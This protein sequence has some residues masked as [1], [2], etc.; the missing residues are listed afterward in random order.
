MSISNNFQFLVKQVETDALNL[1]EDEINL[2]NSVRKWVDEIVRPNA[3][4]AWEKGELPR[5]WM[6]TIAAKGWLSL[7]LAQEYGGNLQPFRMYALL[8][9]ELERGDS[10]LRSFVSVHCSL[11]MQAIYRFGS[12]EQ[13]KKYLPRMATGELIGSFSLTEPD[14]GSD[15]STIKTT[16]TKQS[17]DYLLQGH[18]RWAT[19]ST[20]ADLA[21]IFAKTDEGIRGFVLEKGDRGFE[22]RGVHQKGSLRISES[23]EILLNS[24]LI[25]GDRLLPGTAIGIAAPLSCLSM[26]RSGIAWGMIG[27]ARHCF[28]LALEY[29]KQRRQFGSSLAGKQLVQEK[30]ASGFTSITQTLLLVNQMALTI[31][32]Y[33]KNRGNDLTVTDIRELTPLI[34]MCKRSSCRMARQVIAD[35]RDLLGAN[36]ILLDYE[37]I[38]HMANVESIY[39]YEGTDSIHSLILGQ[40][41]TGI[42]AF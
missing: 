17:M 37:I 14:A 24:C 12:E 33:K 5:Q 1:S 6:Q 4:A 32:K 9:Q 2:R 10:G 23:A 39:T 26:A 38:R 3:T 42:S 29:V 40:A 36:G 28:D 19:S 27:S 30:L 21:V 16:A 25:P 34:S 15:P 13:K 31:E 18:K 11:A 8:C 7:T 41:I 35:C 22:P 20:I